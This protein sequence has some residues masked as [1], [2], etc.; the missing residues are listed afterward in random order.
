MNLGTSIKSTLIEL[1]KDVHYT[2]FMGNGIE[3]YSWRWKIHGAF[4]DNT[5]F[6]LL[7]LPGEHVSSMPLRLC[8]PAVC[9]SSSCPFSPL[10][11]DVA[12]CSALLPLCFPGAAQTTVTP[13]PQPISH[14]CFLRWEKIQHIYLTIGGISNK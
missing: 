13:V 10:L 3:F 8:S 6:C 4:N 7:S 5:L 1:T 12:S 2:Y 14:F 11:S 9:L